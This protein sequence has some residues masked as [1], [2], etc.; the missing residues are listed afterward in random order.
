MV[1]WKKNFILFGGFHAD[2]SQKEP[3]YYNDLWMLQDVEGEAVWTMAEYGPYDDVPKPRSGCCLGCH[4]STVFMYGG[5]SS[6]KQEGGQQLQGLSHT[7]LWQ[8]TLPDMKWQKIRTQGIAPSIRS[9]VSM[10]ADKRRAIFFGGVWDYDDGDKD[11]QSV[12]H[13]DMYTLNWETK[14]W[15]P[16]RPK[17]KQ[18]RGKA[19]ADASDDEADEVAPP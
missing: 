7:D 19:A 5:Y 18:H 15:F 16:L 17:K 12:F 10:C 9:G 3:S 8:I 13:N 11:F 6:Q 4:E 2:K 1:V 14:R